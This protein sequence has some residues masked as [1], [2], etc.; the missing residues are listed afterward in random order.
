MHRVWYASFRA[1][2][3]LPCQALCNLHVS[4]LLQQLSGMGADVLKCWLIYVFSSSGV[5]VCFLSF[6]SH[7]GSFW[8]AY[9]LPGEKKKDCPEPHTFS[10][11]E[12]CFKSSVLTV[13]SILDLVWTSGGSVSVCN[14]ILISFLVDHLPW[15]VNNPCSI[16]DVLNQNWKWWQ[17]LEQTLAHDGL[18]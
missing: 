4:W 5:W 10:D 15:G 6:L 13:S 8:G 17:S 1:K 9:S 16:L 12:S 18:P 11:S 14:L 7:V 2:F 3:A